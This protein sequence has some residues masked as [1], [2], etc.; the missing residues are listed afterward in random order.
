MEFYFLLVATV[1]VRR[2]CGTAV[3]RQQ[4]KKTVGSAEQLRVSGMTMMT[5]SW[6]RFFFCSVFVCLSSLWTNYE[7]IFIIYLP[8]LCWI[9]GEFELFSGAFKF[10]LCVVLC[11]AWVGDGVFD[12]ERNKEANNLIWIITLEHKIHWFNF[13]SRRVSFNEEA[14]I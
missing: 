3:A 13:L 8:Y 7:L 6:S 12:A 10:F 1:T 2:F 5:T 4:R 11:W 9:G 14:A